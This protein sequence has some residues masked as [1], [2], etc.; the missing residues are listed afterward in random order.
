MIV[1]ASKYTPV[2]GPKERRS[3][4]A[5]QVLV[6]K[7]RPTQMTNAQWVDWFNSELRSGRSLD[8]YFKAKKHAINQSIRKLARKNW[9]KR[10]INKSDFEWKFEVPTALYHYWKAQDPHFWDDPANLRSLRRDN[11]DL[12]HC[13][14]KC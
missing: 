3:A 11:D 12:T 7:Q 6:K 14:A 2:P 10:Q 9:G 1:A 4:A 5:P 13:I 8:Q